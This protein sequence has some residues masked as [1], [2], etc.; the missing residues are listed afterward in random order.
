MNV[1]FLAD[2]NLFIVY[3]NYNC[4]SYNS[5]SIPWVEFL[6]CIIHRQIFANCNCFA[7][8]S[9]LIAIVNLFVPQQDRVTI[10]FLFSALNID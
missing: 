7:I 2:E 8:L 10:V 4:I 1:K 3:H 5:M 6:F 9:P